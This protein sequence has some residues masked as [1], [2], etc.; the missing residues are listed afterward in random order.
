V[1]IPCYKL[2]V[3]HEYKSKHIILRG[4]QFLPVLSPRILGIN[5][6]DTPKRCIEVGLKI[7]KRT[8]VANKAISC[9]G[10]VQQPDKWAITINFPVVDTIFWLGTLPD[11]EQQVSTI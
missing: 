10:L 6:N 3:D 7:K 8:T 2:V 4:D 11:M 1:H 5:G 9:I